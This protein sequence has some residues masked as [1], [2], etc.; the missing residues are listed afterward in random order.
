MILCQTKTDPDRQARVLKQAK[1]KV[2]AANP[3]ALEKARDT[4]RPEEGRAP[5]KAAARAAGVL[6]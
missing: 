3:K 5:A 2:D 6:K 4:T 1:A